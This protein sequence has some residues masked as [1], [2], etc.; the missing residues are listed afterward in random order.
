MGTDASTEGTP[1]AQ[2][3]QGQPPPATP[4]ATPPAGTAGGVEGRVGALEGK[5]DQIL[6]LLQRGTGQGPAPAAAPAGPVSI[7][8]E[9]RSQID[10]ARQREAA[11][12]EGSALAA[13]IGALEEKITGMAEQTPVTPPRRIEK[14]WQ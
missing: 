3:G 10:E 1:A 2:T 6:G 4:P 13:R 7:A 14:M 12:Q 8:E 9:V 5:V 11:Q